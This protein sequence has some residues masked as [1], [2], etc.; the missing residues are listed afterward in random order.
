MNCSCSARDCP[1]VQYIRRLLEGTELDQHDTEEAIAPTGWKYYLPH[2]KKVASYVV[3]V[4][5]IAF[6]FWFSMTKAALQM[7]L[8]VLNSNSF[9]WL[10][11]LAFTSAL[12]CSLPQ[13][14]TR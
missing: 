1:H 13:V 4:L 2:A 6:Y 3:M 7:W 5:Q 14:H 10:G 8:A 11:F 9:F 12:I